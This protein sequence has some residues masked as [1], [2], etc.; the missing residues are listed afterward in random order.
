MAKTPQQ[1]KIEKYFNLLV[2]EFITDPAHKD[3]TIVFVDSLGEVGKVKTMGHTLQNK[4]S[5]TT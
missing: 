4:Q 2:K 1:Q 3:I 5:Q